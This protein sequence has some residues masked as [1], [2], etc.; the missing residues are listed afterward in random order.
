LKDEDFESLVS[1]LKMLKDLGSVYHPKEVIE[2]YLELHSVEY[3]PQTFQGVKIESEILFNVHPQ[4]E[5]GFTYIDLHHI[6]LSSWCRPV[7]SNVRLLTKHLKTLGYTVKKERVPYA[8]GDRVIVQLKERYDLQL[9]DTLTRYNKEVEFKD[10]VEVFLER[11]PSITLHGDPYTLHP[12]PNFWKATLLVR[13]RDLFDMGN[14]PHLYRHPKKYGV[15]ET[16]P[17]VLMLL[18][19]VLRDVFKKESISK[20]VHLILDHEDEIASVYASEETPQAYKDLFLQTVIDEVE[21]SLK[22]TLV[23]GVPCSEVQGWVCVVL[24]S[25][26]QDTLKRYGKDS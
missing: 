17:P 14:L 20:W 12:L 2:E 6:L 5:E 18:D 24:I 25:Y 16:A 21:G 8:V 23:D 7:R 13:L 9:P 15:Y 11:A 22:D 1:L 3:L 10:I 26:V 19:L 4:D